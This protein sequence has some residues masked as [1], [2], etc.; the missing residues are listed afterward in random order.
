[1]VLEEIEEGGLLQSDASYLY[2]AFWASVTAACC[3]IDAKQSNLTLCDAAAPLC[4]SHFGEVSVSKAAA[5]SAPH[6][7]RMLSDRLSQFADA[8][9]L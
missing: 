8:I 9:G 1:M 5:P 7:R 6:R 4:R 2:S 3:T